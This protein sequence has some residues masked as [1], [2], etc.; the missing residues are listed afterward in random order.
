M[1]NERKRILELF[2]ILTEH[3]DD[4]INSSELAEKVNVSDRTIKSDI[5]DLEKFALASGSHIEAKKGQGYRL[6]VDDRQKYEPVR[7]QL[8]F[9]FGMFGSIQAMRRT[10]VNDIVRRIICEENYMTLDEIADELYLTRSALREDNK[11][12]RTFLAQ[13]NLRL[14]N[15]YETGPL[16]VGSEYDRRLAMLCV[17]EN[18]YHEAMTFYKNFDY[19]QWFDFDEEQRYDIRHIFLRHL[20]ESKCHIRDDHT[21]RLSRYL[22]LMA[23]RYQ[24]GYKVKFDEE[25]MSF[26]RSFRQYEVTK[27]MMAEI[28]AKYHIV[29]DDGE[30]CGFALQ[31]ISWSDISIEG[32][33]EQPYALLLPECKELVE[34]FCINI[35]NNYFI[36]LAKIEGSY[37]VLIRLMI[38]LIVQEK[39]RLINQL[40][41]NVSIEDERFTFS[42][43]ASYFAFELDEVFFLKYDQHISLYNIATFAYSLQ[44]LLLQIPYPFKPIRAIVCMGEGLNSAEMVRKIIQKRYP[45]CFAYLDIYELYEMRGLD[46]DAY[47]YTILNLPVFSYKYEWPYLL[48]DAIPTQHQ[49]NQVFNE[50]IL[51]GVQLDD[52]LKGLSI[53]KIAVY[54]NFNLANYEYFIDLISFHHGKDTECIDHIKQE[55]FTRGRS[56][57]H[58]KVMILMIKRKYTKEN[59]IEFYELKNEHIYKDCT[60]EYIVVLSIDFAYDISSLRFINDLMFMMFHE[61]KHIQKIIEKENIATLSAIVREALKALPISLK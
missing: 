48:I 29:V 55:L 58:N 50:I 10:R 6:I 45:N 19:L 5:K 8:Q 16:V 37:A 22:C 52:I 24:K 17:F 31:L 14:K 2:F 7:D 53:E 44:G 12:V 61:K 25:Q 51:N 46:K 30:I 42:P 15:N 60:F 34:K 36:D 18:H 13:F 28:T 41:R 26:I 40:I 9:Y 49:L 21:Q 43:I 33:L 4:Y 20:R 56:F 1:V 35:A 38:P 54:R 59:F 23:N 32:E 11:E 27:G 57:I 39:F 3:C 47:D